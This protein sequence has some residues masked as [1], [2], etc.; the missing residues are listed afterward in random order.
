ML[1]KALQKVGSGPRVIQAAPIAQRI[2]SRDT[3]QHDQHDVKKAEA[4][5]CDKCSG[6]T[7]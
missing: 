3:S 2:S 6:K 1:G 7:A 4:A 5:A